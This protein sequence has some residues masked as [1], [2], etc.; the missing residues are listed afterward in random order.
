MAT[1]LHYD[2]TGTKVL[3]ITEHRT[4]AAQ[5]AALVRAKKNGE[6]VAWKQQGEND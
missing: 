6:I 1:L 5:K 2:S 3:R 4:R